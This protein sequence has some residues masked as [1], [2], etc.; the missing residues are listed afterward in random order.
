MAART[1]SKA[2]S[3]PRCSRLGRRM[4]RSPTPAQ[5]KRESQRRIR[6]RAPARPFALPPNEQRRRSASNRLA[7]EFRWLE[8]ARTSPVTPAMQ[9]RIDM[10]SSLALQLLLRGRDQLL[11]P[12]AEIRAHFNHAIDPDVQ[13]GEVPCRTFL[14]SGTMRSTRLDGAVWG[15]SL[16]SSGEPHSATTSWN[17]LAAAGWPM[18]FAKALPI[19]KQ[20]RFELMHQNK[21]HKALWLKPPPI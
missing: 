19:A 6:V 2:T 12:L 20:K 17:L 3:S 14:Y 11:D 21:W 10:K 8:A 18:P 4:S 16:I 9:T 7:R 5:P 13:C 1:L 15:E